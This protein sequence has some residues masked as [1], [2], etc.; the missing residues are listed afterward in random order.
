MAKKRKSNFQFYIEYLTLRI[1]CG[2][3]NAIPYPIA[4]AIGKGLA[5]FAFNVIGINKKRTIERIKSVFPEKSE[6]EVKQIAVKSFQ[7]IILNGVE[8]IRSAKLSKKWIARHVK[9][10]EYYSNALKEVVTKGKGAV[11]M[12]PHSGNWYM[13]AWAMARY[14]I[15]IFAIAA[16]Q[17]NPYINAWMHRQYGE[18]LE[19]LERGSVS[20]MREIISRLHKGHAF[21]ILPDLRVPEEDVIV[22]FLNGEANISHGGAMFAVSTGAPIIVAVMRRE[23]GMHTFTHAATI[24]PNTDA[25]DRREEARRLMREVMGYIDAEIKRSPEHWF[26]FNKRWVLQPPQKR[27]R[28]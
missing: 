6:K 13:A 21:A 26:W 11:I 7:N 24:Y 3:I 18:G 12:V 14:G 22:P 28:T 1:A 8:M 20:V 16:K 27:T 9:D 23:N 17:R 25:P 10:V 2:I 15:P 19:V 5:S 4:S